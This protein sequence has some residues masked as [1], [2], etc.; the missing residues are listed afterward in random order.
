MSNTLVKVAIALVM[1]LAAPAASFGRGGGDQGG[2]AAMGHST[3]GVSGGVR[4]NGAAIGAEEQL[5]MPNSTGNVGVAP[6][7][8]PRISVP[9]V[10][11]F[12]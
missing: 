3:M 8:P 7:S 4:P 10:P 2:G 9:T 12:K 5:A 11:Q 1:V 6:I